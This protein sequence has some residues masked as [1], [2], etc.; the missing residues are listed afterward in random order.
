MGRLLVFICGGV[1]GSAA[2]CYHLY[3]RKSEEAD[4]LK[5]EISRMKEDIRKKRIMMLKTAS[6]TAVAIV[7]IIKARSIY[8][9]LISHS[10]SSQWNYADERCFLVSMIQLCSE[11]EIFRSLDL[12]LSYSYLVGVSCVKFSWIEDDTC[13]L[14]ATH[15]CNI[16]YHSETNSPAVQSWI[17]QITS[18]VRLKNEKGRHKIMHGKDSSVCN[19][20]TKWQNTSKESICFHHQSYFYL[21]EYGIPGSSHVGQRQVTR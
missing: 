1:V 18:F 17:V 19:M 5:H 6:V 4:K 7:A 8:L 21:D 15:I 2:L 16:I 14:K 3:T 13:D 20:I 10:K 12:P 9:R 11:L